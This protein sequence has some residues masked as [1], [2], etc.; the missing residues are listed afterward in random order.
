MK[1]DDLDSEMRVYETASDQ[2]VS[3]SLFMV[4]RLDGRCFTRLTKELCDFEVPFDRRFSDLMV[5]TAQSLMNCGFKVLFAFTESDEISLLLDPRE[6]Q[7]GRKLRKLNSILAGE[8]S[9][10]FSLRLGRAASFDCRISQLPSEDRVVDYFRW[11]S[12]DAARN[13]LNAWCYWKLRAQGI[14][15]RAAADR[16]TGM[17]LD[18]KHAFLLSCGIRFHELPEWQRC[19]I[20]LYWKEYRKPATDPR[21]DKHIFAVRRRIQ[22]DRE[23]PTG[24]EFGDLVGSMLSPN[25]I[26]RA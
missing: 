22:V 20:G 11:R 2:C 17:P 23:L 7:F 26:P 18:H 10:Q 15:K 4:A 24:E 19:G 25:Q 13:T 16:L 5:A 1:F 3:P 8:T 21:T 9:A 12:Q 6:R 14:S